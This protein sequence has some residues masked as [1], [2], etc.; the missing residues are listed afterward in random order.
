MVVRRI[1]PLSVAKIA[2]LLYAII[3]LIVGAFMSLIFGAM[4]S[5][6]AAQ[7]DMPPMMGMLVGAGSIVMMPILYGVLGFV[8]TALSAVIYNVLAGFV[9]GIEIDVDASPAPR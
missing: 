7:S 6:G 5:L 8:T 4:G 1:N 2:G 9:G 3:G